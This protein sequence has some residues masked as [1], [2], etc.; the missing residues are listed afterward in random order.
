MKS[1]IAAALLVLLATPLFASADLSL[2]APYPPFT[3]VSGSSGG[4]QFNLSNNGPDEAKD[5]V[6]TVT[7]TGGVLTGCEAGCHVLDALAYGAQVGIFSPHGFEFDNPGVVTIT[8]TAT[9]STPDPDPSN[10]QTSITVTVSPDPDLVV[11]LLSVPV[12]VDIGIPFSLVIDAYNDSNVVAHDVDIAVSF[13]TDVGVKSL[14]DGCS[15][16]EAGRVVCHT[17]ALQSVLSAY[18]RYSI[19]LVAP[20]TYGDGKITFVISATSSEQDFNP[21]SNI[22]TALTPIVLPFIVTSTANDGSGSLRQAILDA[23]AATA[24]G[25]TRISFH[26]DE[27]SANKWKTIHITSPLPALTASN[28]QIDGATQG[29]T[30][31]DGPEIEISGGGT[32]DGDGL[33]ITS[34]NA[35]I[36]NLAINGFQ[37]NGLSVIG[38][39]ETSTC[40]GY[41]GSSLHDLFIGT[42][43][44]GS[45]ARP[46]ARGIGISVPNGTTFSS[47]LGA[48]L[49]SHSVISGNTRSG[50]FGLSGRLNVSNNRIGVKAH[51]DDPLPNGASGIFVGAGGYGSDIGAQGYVSAG[52]DPA[53]GANVIA[54]NGESG[55]SVASGV[56]DVAVRD[57]RIWGNKLLGIDVG[58]DGPTPDGGNGTIAVP[59]LTLAHFDPLS[60]KTI[61]EGDLPESVTTG[62]LAAA[63]HF[64]ANDTGD[65]SGYGEGQ[66]SLGS[67]RVLTPPHFHFEAAGDLSGQFISAT[68]TRIKFVGFDE[69][70][71]QTSEFSRWLE[72]R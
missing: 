1:P 17:D 3:V 67:I 59:V 64:Y 45:Q 23:N 30:N 61:I 50:I 26:I 33:L 47:V 62:F 2:S 18:L 35:E 57:N 28:I 16:P 42:D 53:S 43:P 9:S 13:R 37:R 11:R 32:V 71:T 21:K 29:A 72:V 24:S 7:A 70:L 51:S 22:V 65:P 56:A 44:T 20:Q 31:P 39:P 55:V 52:E 34:C 10:N 41:G 38:A 63:I 66:R 25:A 5:V 69:L 12:K 49:I 68:A 46:N 15:S 58:L 19:T 36:A 14:P 54:F 40:P 48:T 6:L 60:G 27:P 4:L 8:A